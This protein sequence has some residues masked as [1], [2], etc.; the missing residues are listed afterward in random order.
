MPYNPALDPFSRQPDSRITPGRRFTTV[1]PGAGEFTLYPKALAIWVPAG[2]VN[3]TVTVL[4]AENT[5][6]A[7]E[8]INLAE[9][10]TI[11]DWVV[12]RAVT[13][14]AAGVVVGRID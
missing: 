1:T 11:L 4:P 12:V 8:V 2:T 5:D 3:P 9:G 10:R 7:T 13:A 6:G 14:A